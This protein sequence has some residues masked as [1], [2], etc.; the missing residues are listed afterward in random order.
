M[1]AP[2]FS[3]ENT[4]KLSLPLGSCFFCYFPA[5]DYFLF[6]YRRYYWSG[7]T[8]FSSSSTCPRGHGET[9][10]QPGTSRMTRWLENWSLGLGYENR[11]EDL[12]RWRLAKESLE[13]H[14]IGLKLG[15]LR[16]V[17][18]LGEAGQLGSDGK[19]ENQRAR[20]TPASPDPAH[21]FSPQRLPP[22]ALLL[23]W[24]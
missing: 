23:A 7:C 16:G 18:P 20:A 17:E 8:V 10:A 19:P 15:V 24:T 9:G 22:P 6:W 4:R 12:R 2:A 11:P 1:E 14:F 13:R 3:V 5:K 21:A